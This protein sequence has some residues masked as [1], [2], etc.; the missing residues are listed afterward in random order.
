MYVLIYLVA[1]VMANLAVIYFGPSASIW[2]AFLFIGLDLSLRDKLHD[3]WRGKRLWP[4]MLILI[5]SGSLITVAL[6]YEA[7]QIAI[8]SAVAFLGAG[9]G[10]AIIYSLLGKK[11]YLIRSNGSNVVGAALDSIIFPTLAFGSLMPLIILGQFLA[12]VGGGFIWSLVL[13]ANYSKF[14]PSIP[15]E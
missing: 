11:K 1:I 6:N 15:A 4:K 13:N 9:V 10:D 12:K 8:A 2:I 3:T 5:C 14:Q 7:M